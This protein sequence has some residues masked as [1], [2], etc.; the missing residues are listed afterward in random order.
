MKSKVKYIVHASVIAALYVVL[1]ALSNLF[2]L[3]NMPVQVRLSEALTI[4][5][6]CTPAAVPGLFI[7]C[8]LGNVLT[9]CHILDVLFGSLATLLAAFLTELMSRKIRADK[10]K[11][12]IAPVPPIII[13]TAVIPFVLSYVYNFEGAVYLFALTVFLGELISAGVLGILL[14]GLLKKYERQLF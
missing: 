13:N 7:G 10:P 11:R 5:P 2:G 4:L 8:I 3:S 14:Y 9:G 6:A 1:T 12:I